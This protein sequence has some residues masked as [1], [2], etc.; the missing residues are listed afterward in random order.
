V[1]ETRGSDLVIRPA[2][3]AYQAVGTQVSY[4]YSEAEATTFSTTGL[5][6]TADGREIDFNLNLVMT[7]EFRAVYE[8]TYLQIEQVF[9]DPLVINLD[10]NIAELEDQTC[11]FDIDSDGI[12][13]E[14][15]RLSSRSGYLAYD[16][17]ADGVINDGSEHFGAGSGNG[18]ADLARYD[19]DGNGWI[20]EADEIFA[21][22]LIWMMEADGTS[23]LFK[24]A[25]KG[26]GAISLGNVATEFLLTNA[27]N[28]AQGAI[29]NTGLF[30]YETGAVGSMQQI[31]VAAGSPNG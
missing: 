15:A 6:R 10:G 28:E 21:K 23:S 12:L 27:V 30:L 24:L 22:L 11:I 16:R 19:F 17:N 5:V 14:I 26:I 31:D 18:F 7:R 1:T 25:E 13:D 9:L 8:E 2:F 4:E 3:T 29:R 20:D